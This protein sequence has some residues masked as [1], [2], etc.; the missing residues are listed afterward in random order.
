MKTKF[1]LIFL[2]A[3]I[4]VLL[5]SLKEIEDVGDKDA[6]GI[7]VSVEWQEQTY[8]L[9]ALRTAVHCIETKSYINDYE[10]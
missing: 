9:A 7:P 3:V 4:S 1:V 5:E 8:L 2:K 10:Q 6:D